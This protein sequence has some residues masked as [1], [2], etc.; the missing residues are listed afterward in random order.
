MGSV[1]ETP[2]AH[3]CARGLE[4]IVTLLIDRGANVN[5]M[6]SDTV[7]PIGFAIIGHQLNIV[8][9]LLKCNSLDSSI[10][11]L[12]SSIIIAVK[13]EN[14]ECTRLLVDRLGGLV[15]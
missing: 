5:F 3:A 12:S 6:C 7:P 4:K 1:E 11:S 13:T 8:R 9:M 10:Y 15:S 14:H 2:L